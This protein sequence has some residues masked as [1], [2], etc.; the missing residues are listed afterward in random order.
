M[1]V[2]INVQSVI[3][4]SDIIAEENRKIHDSFIDIENTI[5]Y[6]RANWVGNAQEMC[7]GK[8][9]SIKELFNDSRFAVIDD[10]VRFL[11][12]QVG[13]GYETTER[14]IS[15]AANAFK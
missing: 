8:A 6:L 4:T 7:C 3:D 11:R 9:E 10:Y 1:A 2:Q 13:E 12:L 5:R 15:S 14:V